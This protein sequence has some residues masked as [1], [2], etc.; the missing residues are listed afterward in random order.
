VVPMV[1]HRAHAT[2]AFVAAAG[3]VAAFALPFKLA[4]IVASLAGI[5]AGMAV[6]AWMEKRWTER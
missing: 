3:G 6:F 5:A 4:Y 2:A 1:K